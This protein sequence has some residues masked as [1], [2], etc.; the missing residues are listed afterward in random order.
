M[1]GEESSQFPCEMKDKSL[2]D[3]GNT[4]N[5]RLLTVTELTL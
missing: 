5:H 3:S 2:N 4:H 1:L